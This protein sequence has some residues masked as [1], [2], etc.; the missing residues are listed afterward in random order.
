[1]IELRHEPPDGPAAR[2]LWADYMALVS[3][4]IGGDFV[5]TEE[6]FGTTEAFR[7]PGSAWLVLYEDGEPV[8]C[9]GLRTLEPGVGEI[10]RMFV[11]EAARGRGHARRMLTALEALARERGHTRIRLITTEVFAEARNLYASAGYRVS[12]TW[13]EG[14][15]RDYWMEKD[16]AMCPNGP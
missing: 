12:S 11:A 13:V 8:A 3:A 10:K 5:P 1:V 4:R 2:A 6:I 15:R 7:G 16:L 14:D 9:G